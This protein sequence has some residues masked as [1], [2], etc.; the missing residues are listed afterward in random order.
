MSPSFHRS[1]FRP[2][3]CFARFPARCQKHYHCRRCERV[4]SK[5]ITENNIHTTSQYEH[6]SDRFVFFTTLWNVR[7][8]FAAF[9]AVEKI[10]PTRIR[11]L[12]SEPT[13]RTY[14]RRLFDTI[15]SRVRLH[16][17]RELFRFDF[18]AR[19]GV[20]QMDLQSLLG[21][22]SE[23]GTRSPSRILVFHL[24]YT[25]ITDVCKRNVWHNEGSRIRSFFD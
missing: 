7:I 18:V 10:A 16:F 2:Q 9:T 19:V 14:R 4:Q 23:V 11:S 24:F 15:F 20:L 21:A 1:I 6:R 17:T 13:G 22:V 8:D 3:L 12:R 25:G 5:I